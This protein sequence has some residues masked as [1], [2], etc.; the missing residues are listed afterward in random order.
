V[1]AEHRCKLER[2]EE[3]RVPTYFTRE[4]AESLLPRVRALLLELRDLHE[5]VEPVQE[6]VAE[7]TARMRGNGHAQQGQMAELRRRAQ[8]LGSEVEE[9]VRQLTDWG[10]LVKDLAM[11]LVDFPSQREGREVYL[12]WRLDEPRITW[13]HYPEDGFAGRQPLDN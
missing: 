9:R 12:C 7:L 3:A 8:A 4:E 2:C 6:Q 10:V 11:G 13:W 1:Y 5:Q